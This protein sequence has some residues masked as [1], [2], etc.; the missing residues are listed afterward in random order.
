M[1]HGSSLYGIVNLVIDDSRNAAF[2]DAETKQTQKLSNP[3]KTEK[4]P[5]YLYLVT[6][7]DPL[8]DCLGFWFETGDVL[9]NALSQSI[10]K[11]IAIRMS[12]MST[13]HQTILVGLSNILTRCVGD[14]V[15]TPLVA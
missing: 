4:R 3:K 9:D 6:K 12:R 14:L 10:L 8:E 11:M 5:D 1:L 15:H 7:P 13:I 2:Q